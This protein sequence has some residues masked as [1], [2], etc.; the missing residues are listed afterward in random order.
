MRPH[1]KN[2]IL[3][4]AD[5]VAIDAVAAKMMGYNPMDLKFIRTAHELG[6]GCGKPEEIEIVGDKEAAAQNWH[7]TNP[8]EELTFAAKMQ[9][10][11]YWGNLKKAMEWS[12]KTWMAPWSYL[13]SVVYHDLYWYPQNGNDQV[14]EALQS[15]WGR[16]FHNWDK[17][18]G[19]TDGFKDVGDPPI[20]RI[21]STADLMKMGAKVLATAAQ[22]APEVR[23]RLRRKK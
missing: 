9:H 3:A 21:R 17:V 10:K 8:T 20:A 12:L 15:E 14:Y 16:L 23:A 6:L 19:D 7:F 22:E 11:I 1:V 4:S 5:Q 18:Q 2:V 13:A